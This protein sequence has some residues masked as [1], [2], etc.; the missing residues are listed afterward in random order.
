MDFKNSLRKFLI[1]FFKLLG[2]L[3]LC[4]IMS[5][6]SVSFTVQIHNWNKDCTWEKAAEIE[7][8]F[9]EVKGYESRLGGLADCVD[10]KIFAHLSSSNDPKVKEFLTLEEVRYVEGLL[11]ELLKTKG[12]EATISEERL[13]GLY[14]NSDWWF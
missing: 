8:Y 9:D 6:P 7:R 4:T 1:G 2:S 11:I 5:R 13:D 10:K 14:G 12:Y 3:K